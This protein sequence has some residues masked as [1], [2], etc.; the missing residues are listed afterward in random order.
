MIDRTQD[1]FYRSLSICDGSALSEALSPHYGT[2]LLTPSSFFFLPCGLVL[3]PYFVC[4]CGYRGSGYKKR[5]IKGILEGLLVSV[6]SV[7]E[8]QETQQKAV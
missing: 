4:R 5:P 8:G 1:Q 6:E 7:E 2:Q 3:S